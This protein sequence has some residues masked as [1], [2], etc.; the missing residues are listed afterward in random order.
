MDR[1][2]D[3]KILAW[4]EPVASGNVYCQFMI[5][6]ALHSLPD[7]FYTVAFDGYVVPATKRDGLWLSEL[8]G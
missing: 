6:E 8:L 3:C 5:I 2:A 1:E 7:G 4:K